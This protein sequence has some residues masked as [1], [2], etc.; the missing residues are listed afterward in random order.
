MKGGEYMGYVRLSFIMIAI[1]LFVFFSLAS[2]ENIDPDND[3]SQ[4]CYGENIGWINLQPS[5]GPGITVTD[6]AVSG[7]AWG[8]N[9]GWINFSPSNGGVFND[10][11]GN[12]S[13]YAWGENVGWI[14][15]D[16]AGAGVIINPATGMFSGKADRSGRGA[17]PLYRTRSGHARG[18]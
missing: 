5:Q 4:Y 16:P 10:G 12:L 15:F 7:M 17:A 8:E 6:T 11:N 3:G 14:K 1:V 13:G 2:G 9:V 18:R